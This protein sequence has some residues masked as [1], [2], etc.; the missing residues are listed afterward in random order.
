MSLCD[1]GPML[2]GYQEEFSIASAYWSIATM[3]AWT[4]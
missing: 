4:C 3:I 1:L 2:C